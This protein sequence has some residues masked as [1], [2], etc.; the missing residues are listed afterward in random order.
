MEF[1]DRTFH[2]KCFTPAGR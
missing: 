2:G 1:S